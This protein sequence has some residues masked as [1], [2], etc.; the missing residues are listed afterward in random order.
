MKFNAFKTVTVSL[1]CIGMLIGLGACG[2]GNG[3]KK[4]SNGTITM[5]M[6]HNYTMGTSKTY[7]EDMAKQFEAKHPNVKITQ[8]AIQNEDYE[9]KIQT[10]M[11]DES[12]APDIFYSRGGQKLRDMVDAGQVQDITSKVS[13]TVKKQMKTGLVSHTIDG[14][15]YGVPS[16]MQP[17]GFWYSKDLFKQAGI[18]SAPKTLNELK[19][20]V[21]KLK[22]AGITP[23][24]L[25]AKDAWPVGHWWYHLSMRECP[26]SVF[27]NGMTQKKFSDPCWTKAGDDLQDVISW[28]PFNDGYL[29]TSAQQGASSSAGLLANHKVAME[30]TVASEPGVIKNLTPDGKDLADLGFFP[31]PA[32]EG[33]KGDQKSMMGGADGFACSTKAPKECSEF[34]NFLSEKKNQEQYAVANG[35]IPASTEAQDVVDNPALKEDI[36]AY[37]HA[38][39]MYLWMDTQL[40]TNVGT[41]LNTAVVNLLTGKGSSKDIVKAVEDASKK[42]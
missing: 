2:S 22:Q 31:F 11:Q 32:V 29:T 8:Q 27:K 5:T 6:M 3:S 37:N 12:S 39:T 15:I 30:L 1:T 7:M 38:S 4:A 19:E 10:A 14:K 17:G 41:A 33:A 26:V 40:G 25:A 28:K 20:D 42:G 16:D 21:G 36:D 35:T 18:A 13:D 23:I 9:G 24:G 34:L